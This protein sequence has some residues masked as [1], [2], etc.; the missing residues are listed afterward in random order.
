MLEVPR[1]ASE[2]VFA[3][4]AWGS[5][6]ALGTALPFFFSSME[7]KDIVLTCGMLLLRV[8]LPSDQ[9]T[10]NKLLQTLGLGCFSKT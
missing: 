4:T 8:L 5:R 10:F 6:K 9:M 7:N 2:D 1:D 3:V